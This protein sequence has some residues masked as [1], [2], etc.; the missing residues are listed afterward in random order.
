M[1]V[2][3][4]DTDGDG[5]FDDEDECPNEAGPANNNG[6]PEVVD[7]TPPPPPTQ[8]AEEE[9]QTQTADEQN[10][11]GTNTGQYISASPV[12]PTTCDDQG[13]SRHGKQCVEQYSISRRPSLPSQA[14]AVGAA[15]GGADLVSQQTYDALDGL[16]K[17]TAHPHGGTAGSYRTDAIANAADHYDVDNPY[18][19]TVYENS[20]L[21][22]SKPKKPQEFSNSPV[23]QTY[24]NTAAKSAAIWWPTITI[25]TTTYA[26]GSLFKN[27][28][29]DEN[30]HTTYTYTDF[31]GRVVLKRAPAMAVRT[32]PIMAMTYGNRRM[33]RQRP[34]E[35]PTKPP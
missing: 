26:A 5:I 35:R 3:P 28:L 20:P 30:G 19:E 12:Q 33:C 10:C 29:T 21:G 34:K 25:T 16:T 11:T 32:T 23:A 18:S 9:E 2:T 17:P 14:V 4:T 31:Q 7:T 27:G 8:E 15:P 13:L 6:C 1:I 22:K 24:G